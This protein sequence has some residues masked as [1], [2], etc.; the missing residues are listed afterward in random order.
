MEVIPSGSTH[1][2]EIKGVD[3]SQPV[4]DATFEAIIEVFHAHSVVVFRN[5]SL[6]EQNHVDFS[7]RIGEIDNDVYGHFAH[8]DHN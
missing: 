7:A 1:G 8:P 3:L 4:D 5:Q 2:A 6:S